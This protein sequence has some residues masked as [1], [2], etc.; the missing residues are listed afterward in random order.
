MEKRGFAGDRAFDVLDH[1]CAG[2]RQAGHVRLA[3]GV[4]ADDAGARTQLPDMRQM[5]L[6]SARRADH[7]GGAVGP[8]G[9]AVDQVD[10]QAVR[11]GDQQ[12]FR[13]Q[14][15]PVREIECELAGARVHHSG[16]WRGAMSAMTG[17]RPA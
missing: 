4:S 8:I 11:F 5:C 9:P 14:G 16:S 2:G 15:L 7:D 3:D 6:A 17:A 10:G 12:V 13:S 1:Q